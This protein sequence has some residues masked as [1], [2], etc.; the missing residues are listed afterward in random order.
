MLYR[1]V[2][3]HETYQWSTCDPVY[4]FVISAG[5]KELLESAD[6]RSALVGELVDIRRAIANR[7][8]AA[9]APPNP[10]LNNGYPVRTLH[11]QDYGC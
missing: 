9:P 8:R 7:V 3:F 6:E 4:V 10:N 5:V 11:A 2:T 1:C